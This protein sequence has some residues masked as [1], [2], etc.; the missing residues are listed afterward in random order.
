MIWALLGHE[1]AGVVVKVGADVQSV[2]AGEHVIPP[3]TPE[4]H[5]CEYCLSRKTHLWQT[6]RIV[7]TF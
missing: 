1:G 2:K 6:I 3:Y 7:L 5:G 4:C